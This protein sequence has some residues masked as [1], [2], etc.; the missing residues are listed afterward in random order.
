MPQR[1]SPTSETPK[2]TTFDVD[3]RKDQAILE[4]LCVATLG[5][6]KQLL[7]EYTYWDDNDWWQR[8]IITADFWWKDWEFKRVSIILQ[9]IKQ[10]LEEKVFDFWEYGSHFPKLPKE[11][12]D[13]VIR[14]AY[15]C[16][17][18]TGSI[19]GN[20][21]RHIRDNHIEWFNGLIPPER[22]R[23]SHGSTYTIRDSW[24]NW[25]ST[26]RDPG[27]QRVTGHAY[28][29]GLGNYTWSYWS[30]LY[31]L[32]KTWN[33]RRGSWVV[34]RYIQVYKLLNLSTLLPHLPR[35]KILEGLVDF[36]FRI[37]HEWAIGDYWLIEGL[38][39]HNENF[40]IIEN[41]EWYFASRLR[42]MYH[43]SILEI[44]FSYPDFSFHHKH[45]RREIFGNIEYYFSSSFES[46][47]IEFHRRKCLCDSWL[48]QYF[49]IANR[50]KQSRIL[51]RFVSW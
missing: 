13:L 36:W 11:I 15:I 49:V 32:W 44:F 14:T 28:I 21:S 8:T 33:I 20:L 51:D 38:S 23:W 42:K 24:K 5:R 16:G 35:S 22:C 18:A 43:I 26:I 27:I 48:F 31:N 47:I 12:R 4:V 7:E 17:K 45:H 3:A 9:Y 41:C 25:E 1:E 6:V 30:F 50:V 19:G 37:H 29:S 10:H 34:F 39:C 2:W 40:R 46:D